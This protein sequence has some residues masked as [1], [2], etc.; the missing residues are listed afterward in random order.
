[1]STGQLARSINYTNYGVLFAVAIGHVIESSLGESGI[2][3]FG[4][5]LGPNL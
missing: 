1:M 2:F 4:T 5:S 3:H